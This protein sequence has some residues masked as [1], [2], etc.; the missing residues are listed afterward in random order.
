[1]EWW[2]W[3][4]LGIALLVGEII[5]PGSLFL[6]FFGVGALIVAA[7]VSAGWIASQAVQALW[8]SALSVGFLVLFRKKL[9][10]LFETDPSPMEL[11]ELV[12]EIGMTQSE[13]A[14]G[15]MGSIELRGTIWSA[16]NISNE[17]IPAKSRCKVEKAEGLTVLVSKA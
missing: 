2:V 6:L 17:I 12:G 7:M 15:G 4:S 13:L 3:A 1:M 11:G 10:K 5:L 8:F 9:S 16:K 14:A